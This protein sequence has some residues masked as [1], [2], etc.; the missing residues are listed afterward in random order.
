VGKP[1]TVRF[2]EK[3]P[4]NALRIPFFKQMFPD[5]KFIFLHRD[6]RENISAIIEAWRSGGFVTYPALPDWKGMPW[7]LLLIPGWQELNGA[8]LGEI[9]MRQWR[10][11]NNT[12]LNDLESLPCED[13]CAVNYADLVADPAGVVQ[14]ICAFAGIGYGER[15]RNTVS[16]PLKP[17]RYTIS[18]PDKEKWKRNEA[19]IAP[20]LS[21][22]RTVAGRLSRLSGHETVDE[23]VR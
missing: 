1:D 22:V 17:S 20:Y 5:A 21:Q 3:T 2:L 10:D 7:S 4:K 12:I 16:R 6:A 13:W 8:D 11:T 18:A 19:V 23:T 15:L 9:A 14:K